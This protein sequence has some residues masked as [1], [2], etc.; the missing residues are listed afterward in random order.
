M[1]SNESL[2]FVRYNRVSFLTSTTIPDSIPLKTSET[3]FE[4]KKKTLGSFVV[5]N[6]STT[7]Q[8]DL[9]T[10]CRASFIN[11]VTWTS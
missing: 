11:C 7:G 1:A 8:T 9:A 10:N 4:K 2:F 3:K 6:G 5:A